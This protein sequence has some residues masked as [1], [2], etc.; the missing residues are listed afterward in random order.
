M[1]N[2]VYKLPTDFIERMRLIFPSIK[3][4]NL[5]HTFTEKKPT[6]FRI[7]SLKIDPRE[8]VDKLKM[9]GFRIEKVSWYAEAFILK[10]AG[11]KELMESELYKEGYIYI[12]GLSSMLPPLVLAP[13]PGEI[14]LD[15]TSAPGSKTTQMAVLMHNQGR[16]VAVEQS[17][18]R[19]FKLLNNLKEQ[20]VNNTEAVLCRGE[21]IWLK[22]KEHFD[23]VLLDAPCSSEGR[24][25]TTNP[26]TFLFW[27]ENKVKEMVRKQKRLIFSAVQ[28]AKVGGKILYSTC[29]FSP[30]E[31]EGV[32]N[33]VLQRFKGKII[34]QKIKLNL[35]PNIVP[36]LRKWQGV[37]FLPEIHHCSRVLPTLEMEG[38]FLCLL[39]KINSTHTP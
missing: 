29:T 20:G 24:F 36:G 38:F 14:V 28:S 33:W 11:K 23:K 35:P 13:L 15:L 30:E 16:I 27:K 21:N 10:N 37:E 26:R 8:A 32:I 2:A 39:E 18:E 1:K 9:L 34:T 7:N 6:T 12:Q 31:N 25:D 4:P 5:M 19:F 3:F 22:Y 17:K